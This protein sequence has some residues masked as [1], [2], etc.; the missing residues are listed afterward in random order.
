MNRVTTTEAA[1]LLNVSTETVRMYAKLGYLTGITADGEF[2]RG[3]K[4]Q[5]DAAEVAAFAEGGA[6]AAKAYR[7]SRAALKVIPVR[8]GRGKKRQVVA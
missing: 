8:K 7:E 5:F 3:K 6:P 2:G 4:M 1:A